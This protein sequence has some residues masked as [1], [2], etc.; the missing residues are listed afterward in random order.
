VTEITT[1]ALP[2]ML[3]SLDA[4]VARGWNNRWGKTRQ[5]SL[6]GYEVSLVQGLRP[7]EKHHYKFG[8]GG[9]RFSGEL[10]VSAAAV[11]KSPFAPTS[12]YTRVHIG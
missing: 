8:L 1:I 6:A 11:I 12:Y 5:D 7:T 10:P 3:V 9:N 4:E 2:F